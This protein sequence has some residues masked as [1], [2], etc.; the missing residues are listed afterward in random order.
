MN[1]DIYCYPPDYKVLRNRLGLRDERTLELVERQLVSN[2]AM[3]P[4]QM[5]ILIYAISA[6]FTSNCFKMST[7]EPG[8][9]GK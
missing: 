2:R 4:P 9:S 1:D 8:K 3:E 6:R 7:I 5:A